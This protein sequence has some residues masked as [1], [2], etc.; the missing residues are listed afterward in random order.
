MESLLSYTPTK[1]LPLELD[2]LASVPIRVGWTEK[3]THDGK[4][5]HS[6]GKEL[7]EG[8]TYTLGDAT[9]KQL[10][11]EPRYGDKAWLRK[12]PALSFMDMR[13]AYGKD[14]VIESA[15]RG[16]DHNNALIALG[17]KASPKSKHM[18]GRSLD[19]GNDAAIKWMKKN[20]PKYGWH[21]GTYRKNKGHFNYKRK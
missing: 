4:T 10:G 6:G 21:F 1:T 12:K 8:G 18:F 9:K 13:D 17:I 19:I 2:F 16:V 15:Y 11:R 5:I 20:G 14:I 7:Y 3:V